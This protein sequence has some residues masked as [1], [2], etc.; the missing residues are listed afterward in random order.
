MIRTVCLED[1]K[2]H[3]EI[4]DYIDEDFIVIN[5]WNRLPSDEKIKFDCLFLI[6]CQEGCIRLEI[7]NRIYLLQADDLIIILPDTVITHI[8]TSPRCRINLAFFS[9]RFL[10]RVLKQEKKFW[11]VT[12][13]KNPIVMRIGGR[14]G[15]LCYY[16]ELIIAEINN[17]DGERYHHYYK[18]IIRYLFSAL[19]CEIMIEL[20]K[21]VPRNDRRDKT[22]NNLKRADCI[23]HR[24][25]EKLLAD[26]GTHRSVEYYADTLFYS[27]KHLSKVI[28][29]VSG[30]S[31]LE[32]I[33]EHAMECVK[34]RLRHSDKS[35][36]EIAEEFNF[37]SQSLFGKYVRAHLG[38]SPKQYRDKSDIP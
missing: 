26:N 9:I 14:N 28:K 22:L 20:E 23:F 38:M 19:F 1:F 35:I 10:G 25:M 33:N 17:N 36:K 18:E 8:T 5:N 31:L 7:D 32:L 37:S 12:C 13:Y 16:K 2:V 15:H 3:K 6:F 27:P 29:E 11:N 4:I 34:Y 21:T 24:F 30:R